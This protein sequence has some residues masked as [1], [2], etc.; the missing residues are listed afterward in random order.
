VSH[1]R[2]R[3]E[4]NVT[5]VQL[6]QPFDRRQLFRRAGALA[7]VAGPAIVL[8]SCGRGEP[9]PVTVP[10]TVGGPPNWGALASSLQGSVV[11]PTDATFATDKLLFDTRFDGLSPAAIAFCRS[12]TDVQRCVDFAR[13]S[14]VQLT[15]RSGGHSYAGYST[16]PG[17]IVDV[18]GMADVTV[19]TGSTAVVGAGARLIDIYGTLGT[20]GV[21]LPG[22]SCP[23]VG[24][25][26]LTLGGGIGVLGRRYGLACDNVS[27]LDIVTADGRLVTCDAEQNPDLYWASRGG[28]GG[29]FGIVT[30]FT[31]DVHPIPDIALFTLDWPWASAGTVLDAWLR[32]LPSTPDELW[33]NCQLDS[34]GGTGGGPSV[35]V[36]GVYAGAVSDCAA[37]LAPLISAVAVAP[38]DQFVGPETYERA[39]MIEAGCEDLSVAQCHLPSQN[40]AG[41]LDRSTFA[42]ASAYV[43]EPFPAAAL[44]AAT[45]AVA[46]ASP[47]PFGGALIFNAYGGAIARVP[48]DATAFAHRDASAGIQY[49]A[50]WDPSAPGSVV[51]A[52]TAWLASTSSALDPYTQGAYVNYIDPA[53][54]DYLT[55]YYGTNLARLVDV[56]RAV[57]PD[58][59]FHFAQSIPTALPA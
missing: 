4:P 59:V 41:T 24:I 52:A 58:D 53:Q 37:A 15:A 9:P 49:Y 17:L 47:A 36:T 55:A 14:G 35:K 29:N 28:G 51:D 43:F 40:A 6:A 22:G 39:M 31:F 33:A 30:S 48:G 13:R 19:A 26:G 27:S 2:A 45:Q 23:T 57:D 42:A 50:S 25:A 38:S 54:P 8:G 46:D 11:L 16:C 10:T 56:K 18:T 5:A 3:R 44:D 21:L 1:G 20:A 32:W 7:A 12:P 34:S